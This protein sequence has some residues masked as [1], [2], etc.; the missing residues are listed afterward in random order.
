VLPVA[1]PVAVARIGET[2]CREGAGADEQ[3]GQD[4][5][6]PHVRNAS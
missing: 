2:A 5:S 6:F 3:S 1:L 4:P